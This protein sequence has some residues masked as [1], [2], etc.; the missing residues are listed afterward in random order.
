M[1]TIENLFC[2]KPPKT[3]VA[4]PCVLQL[5][6]RQPA[7]N[8]RKLFLRLEEMEAVLTCKAGR[9]VLAVEVVEPETIPSMSPLAA[10]SVPVQ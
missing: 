9:I 7:A 3:L 10:M 2:S 5:P 4:F 6:C 1:Q 8:V